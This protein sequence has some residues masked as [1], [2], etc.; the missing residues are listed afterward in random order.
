[1]AIS[2]CGGGGGGSG[3]VTQTP[4]PPQP[5][6][7]Q[8]PAAP[9]LTAAAALKQIR[10]NWP[11]VSGVTHYRLMANPDGVSGLTQVGA[12]IAAAD[13]TARIDVAV[14]LHDWADAR[15][16]LDACNAVG[17]TPSNQ[18]GVANV[19]LQSIGYFKPS[20]PGAVD[21]FGNIVALSADGATIAVSSWQEDSNATGVN[22]NQA[23]ESASNSGA[24]YVFRR[25]AT[26]TWTQ[27]AYLKASNTEAT[28]RF[29]RDV[30]LS[31]DGNTLVVSADQ[32]DSNATGI[33][34]NGADNSFFNSG[35]VYVFGRD[36]AGV[37]TQRAYLKASN[38]G[39]NDQFG[40][41]VS[42]SANGTLLAVGAHAE[43]SAAVGING[44]Q[45]NNA[46]GGAGAVYIF[47]RDDNGA[48]TQEAYI[49]SS[50]SESVDFFGESVALSG[51]ATTLAVGATNEDSS[52]TGIGG[53]Q[54]D[55]AAADAGAVYV[56]RR[57]ANGT[58]SQ[59]A[60]VKAAN[61][62]GLDHFG[63]AVALNGDGSTMIVAAV[64]EDSAATGIDGNQADNLAPDAGAVYVFRRD[65][66]SAWSQQAYIK[67]PFADSNDDFGNDVAVS[68]DGNLIAVGSPGEGSD[69]AGVGEPTASNA[70][71]FSGA[72]HLF[73][74]DNGAWTQ[75]A[76]VK[77]SNPGQDGFGAAIGLSSDAN[78]LI[79]GALGEDGSATGVNGDQN[80]AFLNNAGALYVY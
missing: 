52:A 74:F 40:W 45:A 5:P 36:D 39:P 17:C 29:G 14:H 65:S 53:N 41:S 55:S 4:P 76:Y 11:A 73:R 22:G 18:V 46:A 59:E 37:W 63:S 38:T 47:L 60:Y 67:A 13:T 9:Q 58:W 57:A 12:N 70:L 33:N 21:V 61:T 24:V 44:N 10:F 71:P 49:K 31:E 35:A 75:R 34:G 1:M 69:A 28:D 19:M 2:A 30:A 72:A 48:W 80:S 7:P 66:N 8:A 54:A 6:A 26:G 3:P 15:Y 62:Q 27:Q 56:F 77:A 32:E 78:T 20:N 79:V 43:D 50:N 64:D 25:D 51:D 23:D 16:V 42:L 68:A